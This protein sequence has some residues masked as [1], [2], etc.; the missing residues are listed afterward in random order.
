MENTEVE[1]SGS[2]PFAKRRR[3][4]DRVALARYRADNPVCEVVGCWR[5]ACPTPHHIR[6]VS[7]GGDDV[8]SNLLSLCWSHHVG[9]EGWHPLGAHRW[10]ERFG[11][12]LTH[13]ARMKVL[14]VLGAAECC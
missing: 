6:N 3:I 7:L 13:K 4:V 5:E 9:S 12:R 11:D 8:P 1:P 2:L 14:R 10:F